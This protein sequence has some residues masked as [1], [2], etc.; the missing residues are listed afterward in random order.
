M[1]KLLLIVGIAVLIL[2]VLAASRMMQSGT[3]EEELTEAI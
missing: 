2:S 3:A 1:G